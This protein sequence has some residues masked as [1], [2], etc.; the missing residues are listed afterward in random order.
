MV[1]DE[2]TGGV[3]R[4]E[5]HPLI[6]SSSVLQSYANVKQEVVLNLPSPHMTP[7]H[8]L[9]LANKVT[10]KIAAYDGVVITHGT[11]T[12]E[13]TAFFLDFVLDTDKPVVLTGAMRAAGEIGADGLYNLIQSVRTAACDESQRKGVLVVMNDEIHSAQNVIKTS[14]TNAASFQ[15]P[16]FGPFGIITADAV[17]FQRAISSRSR[18]KINIENLSKTVF[19]LKAYAGM[20]KQLLDAVYEAHPDGVVIE[21]LGSG[22]LPPETL[23]PIQ[24]M[25]DAGIPVVLVSRCLKGETHPAYSYEGG[26]KHLKDMGVILAENLTGPKARLKLL[27]E[28]EE[29]HFEKSL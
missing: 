17:Q 23:G 14:T 16:E 2:K 15:S 20:E 7:N 5:A 26:G 24:K 21:A 28:L 25:L 6:D 10:S 12:M 22:N 3:N 13:E 8:M 29:G 11:D 4:T 9:T 18:R 27:I 19:L 1:E